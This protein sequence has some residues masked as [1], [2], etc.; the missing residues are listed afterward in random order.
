MVVVTLLVLSLQ[1]AINALGSIVI[2]QLRRIWYSELVDYR[3]WYHLQ[4]ASAVLVQ[5]CNC[6]VRVFVFIQYKV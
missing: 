2:T 3:T 1:L 6:R 4:Y 5:Y